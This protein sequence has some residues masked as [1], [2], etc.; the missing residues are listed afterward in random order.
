MI[1]NASLAIKLRVPLSTAGRILLLACLLLSPAASAGA[2]TPPT[3]DPSAA[4]GPQAAAAPDLVIEN[5]GQYAAEARFVLMR[6]D[7]RIWLT[8]DALWLMAPDPAAAGEQMQPAK[9]DPLSQARRHRQQPAS[10]RAG[11]AIRFTFPGAN[12][13]TTLEPYGRVPT[14]VSYLIGSDPSRWQRDVPIWSGVRY[15]ELYPGVDLVI[16]DG[17]AATVPWRLEARPGADLSAVTLRAE[18]ADAVTGA[19]GGLRLEMKGRTINVA[20]PAW[21]LA[22]QADPVRSAIVEQAGQDTF[23]VAPES[24]SESPASAD[25]IDSPAD[26]V[27]R[28]FL[29]GAAFDAGS[30]VA[31]D[32]LGNAYV[33]GETSSADFPTQPGSYDPSYNG[34]TDAFVAK[35]N[36]TGSLL[37]ATYLGGSDLD[38]GWGIAV[39][40]NLAYVVGETK[41]SNFPVIGASVGTDIFIAALNANGSNFRYVSRLGGDGFDTGYG[42]AVAGTDAYVVGTTSSTNLPGC[43]PSDGNDLVVAHLNATGVPLYT[44]CL[45]SSNPGST[46][47]G[48]AIAVHSGEA[49]VTGEGSSDILVARFAANGTLPAGGSTLIGG[50]D[51]DLGSGIAVDGSGNIYI[52]G[53]TSS[54]DF[55]T[56]SGVQF[57]GG[58]T[59][60]V[61]VKLLPALTINFATYLGGNGEDDGH[62]IAVD[63][64]EGLYV[65]GTTASS[66]FPTT[67]G[68]YNSFLN[69]GTDAFVARLHKAS[70]AANKLTYSTYLG[71][72][73]DD[74]AYGVATDTGGNA[75]ITG[76]GPLPT[77]PTL[78][79][80]NAFVAKLKISNPPGAPTV[81]ISGSGANANLTWLTVPSTN[82]YQVFR[83]STPYFMPGDS[84]SLLPLFEPSGLSYPDVG[85]L[86]PVNAYFYV[87]KA[88]S[89]APAAGANSNRVGKFTFQLTPG[90]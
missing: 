39:D 67:F 4:Q 61:V 76:N 21:S 66:N 53:S 58:S 74:A 8:D 1:I 46:E 10:A 81:T 65:T 5:I 47:V 83:S 33:T 32:I 27:Y 82:K 52:A 30:G 2:A 37:Y 84:S 13:A 62:A 36:T 68:A 45:G 56:T 59:D 41:S 40:G 72:P 55:P 24:A 12:P 14:H 23:V 87:V 78:T 75:F 49:Y 85:A 28:T 42:I 38:I 48:Y 25:E 70:L 79:T 20:L 60:A 50:S 88:V 80:N 54:S 63:T 6:G 89:A 34:A 18:G 51:G 35:I 22:G 73:V 11:T 86:T 29:G 17:A 19:M 3:A 26:L 9:E 90:Q 69:G 77:D 57:G 15:R 43:A 7:Q 16:G 31:V 64:V 71:T 44:T